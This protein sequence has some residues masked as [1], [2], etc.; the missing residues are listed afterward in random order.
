MSRLRKWTNRAPYIAIAVL[1][2]LALGQVAKYP[3]V[4]ERVTALYK[5]ALSAG[6]RQPSGGNTSETP[7]HAEHGKQGK[8]PPPTER[9]DTPAGGT[10]NRPGHQTTGDPNGSEARGENGPEPRE[11]RF[12][13]NEIAKSQTRIWQAR[14]RGDNSGIAREIVRLLTEQFGLSSLDAMAITSPLLNAMMTFDRQEADYEALVLP[15]LERAFVELRRVSGLSFDPEAAASAELKW[16]VARRSPETGDPEEVGRR[17]A[18]LYTV[19]LGKSNPAIQEAG[20]LRAKAALLVDA[21][22]SDCDWQELERLLTESFEEL[23]KA[24]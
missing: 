4:R 7:N 19:V 20:R 10:E 13:P 15:D 9:G 2:V 22:G 24:L 14:S 12:D 11:S 18:E 17:I 21:P 5:F 1:T 6:N 23:K 16:W 8:A 3:W